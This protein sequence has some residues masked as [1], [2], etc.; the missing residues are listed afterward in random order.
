MSEWLE[1]GALVRAQV[2]EGGP[3]EKAVVTECDRSPDRPYRV[4]MQDCPC[5]CPHFW[6][7]AD[8]VRPRRIKSGSN[9]SVTDRL[10]K[11]VTELEQEVAALKAAPPTAPAV[12]AAPWRPKVGERVEA[13]C[14]AYG[15]SEWLPGVLTL[16]DGS[17]HPYQVR[18]DDVFYRNI[19]LLWFSAE[20]VRPVLGEATS[21]TRPHDGKADAGKAPWQ[22]LPWEAL[23][24]VVAVLAHGASKYGA[25]TWQTVPDGQERY[26]GALMRHVTAWKF[27]EERDPDSGLHHLAHVATNALFILALSKV[28]K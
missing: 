18:C 11:R 22:L 16:D 13:F 2:V 12:P 27:G 6:C 25:N 26:F 4:R 8:E 5:G 9:G 24:D 21:V 3:W 19:E 7:R 1:V 15:R 17:N 28:A 23:A 20:N 14:S 10:R